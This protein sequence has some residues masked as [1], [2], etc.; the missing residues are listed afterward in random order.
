MAPWR[1]RQLATEQPST[2]RLP[3]DLSARRL[4]EEDNYFGLV[5]V[6]WPI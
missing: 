2:Y 4:E 6:V 3:V 1:S 5:A